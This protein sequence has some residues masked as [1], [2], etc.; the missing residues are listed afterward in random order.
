MRPCEIEPGGIVRMPQR[1]SEASVVLDTDLVG[2]SVDVR[3]DGFAESISKGF[4]WNAGVR[5][6]RA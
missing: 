2:R 4:F 3:N 6:W 1:Q 5:A